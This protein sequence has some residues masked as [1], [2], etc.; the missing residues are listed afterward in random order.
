[1][2][3]VARVTTLEVRHPVTLVILVK[4]GNPTR[5]GGLRRSHPSHRLRTVP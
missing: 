4:P 3:Y 2:P 5:F 1:M